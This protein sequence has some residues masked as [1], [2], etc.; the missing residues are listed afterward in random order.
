LAV[1]VPV[2]ANVQGLEVRVDGAPLI[3]GAWGVATP[4]D[5][6]SHG[7][8]A[9]A[10][11]YE[12]WSSSIV[13]TGEAQR[14]QV[15]IPRLTTAEP[16]SS[17]AAGLRQ[18]VPLR[19]QADDVG[20]N[21]RTLG[22][23]GT[24]VG[25]LS[26]GV[27]VGFLVQ[28]GSKLDE[29]DG[30]CPARLDCTNDEERDLNSLTRDARS[31]GTLSTVGFVA[32]GVLLAGGIAAVVLARKAKARTEAAWILPAVAPNALGLTGGMKW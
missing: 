28:K 13:V 26:L 17:E 12:T 23:V 15:Q 14:I 18:S 9:R 1:E 5:S 10:P 19:S 24:G 27:G 7:V 3:A 29:R 31:A 30:V 6:G 2:E 22:W 21:V 32:G 20:G 25:L 16:P 8:E 11:G 4:I